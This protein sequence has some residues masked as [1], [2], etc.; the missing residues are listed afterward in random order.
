MR[1]DAIL[2]NTARGP[3]VDEPA[4]AHALSTGAIFGA[5]VDVFETEPPVASPLLGLTNVVLSDHTG[6]YSEAT[7]ANLQRG[8]AEQAVQIATSGTATEAVNLA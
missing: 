8:A 3:L 1:K 6:W 2:I 4:L 5:G 7:V